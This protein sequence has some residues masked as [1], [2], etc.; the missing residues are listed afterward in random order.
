MKRIVAIASPRNTRSIAL[1]QKLGMTLERELDL[2]R[3]GGKSLLF[4][5]SV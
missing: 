5:R 3:D 1:L 4:A 2:P